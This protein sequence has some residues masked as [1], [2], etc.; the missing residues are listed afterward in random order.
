MYVKPKVPIAEAAQQVTGIVCS[1]SGH[2]T[3]RGEPVS[4]CKIGEALEKFWAFLN[5]FSFPVLVAHNGRR[6]DF[7]VFISCVK[8]AQALQK[9]F[10]TITGFIDSLPLFK[11]VFPG[12]M[13]YKQEHLVQTLLCSSY[14]A[15]DAQ[16]D[17]ESLGH[18]IIHTGLDSKSLLKYSYSPT[19]VHNSML[20]NEEKNCNFNSLCPLISNGVM[21]RA[22][23]E[24]VAGSGLNIKHLQKIFIRD[25]E[26]GL[27]N[28]FISKNSEDQPRVTNTKRV[29][30]E[31]IPKLAEYFRK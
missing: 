4:A 18:L 31:V 9:M 27:K 25:G 22:T 16:E 24:N 1:D 13:C 19:A 5:Q 14:S 8:S 17:V 2:M 7:P 15:H 26:D 11:K 21:K 28:V 3:V 23:A 12:Q 30:E 29:L 10:D 20:F 6:F